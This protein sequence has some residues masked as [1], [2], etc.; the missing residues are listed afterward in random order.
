MHLHCAREILT[1]ENA[2]VMEIESDPWSYHT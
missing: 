2:G 1:T